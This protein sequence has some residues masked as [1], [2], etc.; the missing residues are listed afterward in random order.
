MT[1][2]TYGQLGSILSPYSPY[3]LPANKSPAIFLA[4]RL[5]GGRLPSV[6]LFGVTSRYLA[7]ALNE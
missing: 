6:A 3:P 4:T 7:V 2:M 1:A 5:P